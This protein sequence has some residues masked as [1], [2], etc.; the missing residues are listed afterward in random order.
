MVDSIQIYNHHFEN[1]WFVHM[2]SRIY[3]LG[4]RVPTNPS[5]LSSYQ[6]FRVFKV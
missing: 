3:M 1:I 4:E 6:F 2:V 5:E